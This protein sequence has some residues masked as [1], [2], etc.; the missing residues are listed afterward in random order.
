MPP[1][2]IPQRLGSSLV[3]WVLPRLA[4]AQSW[5]GVAAGVNEFHGF[6]PWRLLLLLFFLVDRGH[7]GVALSWLLLEEGVDLVVGLGNYFGCP[8]STSPVASRGLLLRR[9]V[10]QGGQ[11]LGSEVGELDRKLGVLQDAVSEDLLVPKSD[12]GVALEHLGVLSNVGAACD[13]TAG[14]D[15][16]K[17]EEATVLVALVSKSKVDASTVLGGS[18][19]QVGH[20]AGDIE[21]QLPL[22]L[23]RHFCKPDL[24]L[25]GL[26]ATTR[27]DLL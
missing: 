21:G 27:I 1:S 23:L 15:V 6:L 4:A 5:A 3:L 20:N 11:V 13:F 14:S 18:P 12:V 26:R 22:R 2:W 24:F 19:H 16:L 7:L 10:H 17:V 9:G 8:G 25:L